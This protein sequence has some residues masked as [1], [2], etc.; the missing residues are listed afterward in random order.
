MISN[1]QHQAEQELH[2][3]IDVCRNTVDRTDWRIW[4]IEGA[5]HKLW[6]GTQ[7]IYERMEVKEEIA[8]AW[9]RSKLMV[10]ANAYQTFARQ[11]LKVIMD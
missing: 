9:V 5:Y 2:Q 7:Y 8:K 4:E 10:V 1:K 6:Q 3:L 11:G